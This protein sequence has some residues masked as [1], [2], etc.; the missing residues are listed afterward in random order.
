VFFHSVLIKTSRSS[1]KALFRKKEIFF[2]ISLIF[3]ALTS[4]NNQGHA[5]IPYTIENR[6]PSRSY[7]T[8]EWTNIGGSQHTQNTG[9]TTNMKTT[10]R[11]GESK[12]QQE[13]ETFETSGE[14]RGGGSINLTKGT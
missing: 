9:Q 4:G 10:H 6:E 11:N 3:F 5:Y 7:N 8:L 2:H 1:A 13:T 14:E 12:M